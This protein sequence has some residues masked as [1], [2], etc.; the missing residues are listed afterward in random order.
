M[1]ENQNNDYLELNHLL[2]PF[3]RVEPDHQQKTEWEYALQ[4]ARSKK[5]KKN[6]WKSSTWTIALFSNLFLAQ[7]I[8]LCLPINQSSL[9]GH[10]IV[11]QIENTADEQIYRQLANLTAIKNAKL[12]QHKS[13][14][15]SLKELILIEN[16][17]D[18]DLDIVGRK[19]IDIK[20]IEKMHI[21]PIIKKEKIRLYESV[22][23]LFA[24]EKEYNKEC[25]DYFL[26]EKKIPLEES[27]FLPTSQIANLSQPALNNN[28]HTDKNKNRPSS[29]KSLIRKVTTKK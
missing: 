26:K 12:F 19:I 4:K 10:A 13:F 11:I 28:F 29:Y 1:E 3:K 20:G 27:K 2:G 9:V 14:Q 23:T 5:M 18:V 16:D 24:A 21:T 25:F 7:I 17:L 22:T 15:T 8:F 6:G